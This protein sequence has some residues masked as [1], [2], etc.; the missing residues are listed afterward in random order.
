MTLY[1]WLE[2]YK[3]GGWD[4]LEEQS[5]GAPALEINSDFENIVVAFWK[6]DDKRI[7]KYDQR[8]PD[9]LDKVKVKHFDDEEDE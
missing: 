1:R 5:A 3:K 8:F 6:Q 2:D 4:A 7:I 9:V